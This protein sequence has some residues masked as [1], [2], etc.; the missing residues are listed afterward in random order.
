[1][2]EIDW[3]KMNGLVPAIV[4]DAKTNQVLMLGYMNEEALSVTEQTNEVTFYSR[5]KKRLWTKGESSGNTLKCM[6]VIKDCDNDCLLILADPQGPTC[7]LNN[8]S[9]F[10]EYSLKDLEKRIQDRINDQGKESY[11]VELMNQ[12]IKRIAQ[13]VGEE[14][15]E[16]T[17]AAMSQDKKEIINETADLMYHLLVLLNASKV[18]LDEVMSELQKRSAR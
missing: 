13:K 14:A 8:T 2:K 1:M 10:N 7:H 3:K 18:S 5:S 15:V 9:C 12:G 4:Q 6:K 17:L 11:T 16:V